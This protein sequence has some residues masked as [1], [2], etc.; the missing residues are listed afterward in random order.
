MIRKLILAIGFFII[1]LSAHAQSSEPTFALLVKFK[2]NLPDSVVL[3]TMNERKIEFEKL[4]GLVQKYYMRE[5]ASGEFAGIYLW[6]TA[7]DCM[8]YR[9]SELAKTIKE[10]Y[11]I[12]GNV[13]V[14][15]FDVLFP[16]RRP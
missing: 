4:P 15:L 3:K 14:E 13:R 7:Q 10:A 6:A 5:P 8:D 9:K 11:Q 2:S 16:L 12:Q 1:H